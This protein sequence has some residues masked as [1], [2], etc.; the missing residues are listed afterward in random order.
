MSI[1]TPPPL[2]NSPTSGPIVRTFAQYALPSVLGMV[3]LSSATVVDGIFLGNFVG[4][5]ALAAANL[6]FP[7]GSLLYALTLMLAV[8]GSVICGKFL[9][10]KNPAAASE[11]FAAIISACVVTSLVASAIGIGFIEPLTQLLGANEELAPLAQTYLTII[12]FFAPFL[13]TGFGLSYFV[14]VDGHPLMAAIA[15]IFSA[16]MNILLDWLFI[17]EF[18]WGIEGAAY[19]TGI[20][21]AAIIIPL[22]PYFLS[23]NRHLHFTLSIKGIRAIRT[24]SANGISE[25]ANEISAGVITL[26]FNW[27][28]ITT[29]GV[30]GVAAYTVVNYLLFSGLLICYG[31]SESLQP[32]VSQ[33]LGARNADRIRAFLRIG[34]ASVFLTGMVIIAMLMLMP[35]V[36]I[37]LFLDDQAVDVSEIATHFVRLFWP[38]FL[39]SGVNITLSSYFTAMHKPIHSAAIALSRSLILPGLLLMVLPGLM[40]NDGIYISIPIAEGLTFVLASIL[41]W[42]NQ[43]EFPERAGDKSEP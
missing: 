22:L 33:N 38:A 23:S 3:A 17:V 34:I 4:V 10:E 12:L 20:S 15:L 31:I 30:A 43:P 7:V 24:A 37:G 25:F 5:S 16:L 8:G 21:E 35:G 36:L 14:K 6:T 18:G 11:V 41:Y 9:G 42:F 27:I 2:A 40:G 28:M 26:L 29:M 1:S 19:A 32:L 39:F 13:M